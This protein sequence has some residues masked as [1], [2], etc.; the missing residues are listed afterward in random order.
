MLLEQ[1]GHRG[2]QGELHACRIP[3]ALLAFGSRL[4]LL[5]SL[6]RQG[7]GGACCQSACSS[8]SPRSQPQ[9]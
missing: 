6:G 4:L 5:A 1:L 3:S 8:C 2:I 9:P 7:A